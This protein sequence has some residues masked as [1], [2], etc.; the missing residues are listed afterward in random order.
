MESCETR[1]S[2]STLSLD[3]LPDELLIQ[4]FGHLAVV[5][6]VY[7]EDDPLRLT[8][9]PYQPAD[10]QLLPP[11]GLRGYPF[12]AQVC[13]RW[14]RL[15]STPLT[16]QLV[17]RRL[18]VDLGHELIT[19]VHT[20]LRWSSTRPTSAEFAAALAATRLS[21]NKVVRFLD[22]VSPHVT[23]LAVANSEGFEADDGEYVSLYDKHDFGPAHL[24][25]GL[26]LMRSRLTE[27]VLYRCNDLLQPEG[28]VWGLIGA[29]QGLRSLTVEGLRGSLPAAQAAE[30][31]ELRQLEALV[32]SGEEYRPRTDWT[33]GLD[34]LPAAWS[35][36][37]SLTKLVLRSHPQ[38]P[39]LP[40]WLRGLTGLRHLDVSGCGELR[41]EELAGLTQLH[42]LVLQVG[43]GG[44]AAAGAAA[45]AAAGH[46][47]AAP[48]PARRVVPDL[49]P[50]APSLRSLSLAANRFT[51]LPEWLPRMSRLEHLDVSYNKDLHILA[52]LTG[53]AAL[54]HLRLLDFRAVHVT[55]DES[56]WGEAKCATMQHLAKLARALKRRCPQPRLLMDV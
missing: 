5:G 22:S 9:L 1:S 40:P 53:L 10:M 26:A 55:A 47:G 48:T 33:A 13:K 8:S 32:L 39:L 43:R 20:P 34:A 29:L 21:A 14:R 35:Q 44:A 42:V 54:P 3:S 2:P 50:L 51:A 11:T 56:Y 6:D 45:P 38:L 52:P 12:L 46:G 31:G 37:T 15:L 19:S 30:L 7:E 17:W 36:L 16:Q 27:L 25:F 23:E 4:V 24:G 49:S 28:G 18:C 41:L